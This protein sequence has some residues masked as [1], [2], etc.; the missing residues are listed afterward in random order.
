MGLFLWRIIKICENLSSISNCCSLWGRIM[1]MC[2]NLCGIKFI[3]INIQYRFEPIFSLEPIENRNFRLEITPLLTFGLWVQ[4]FTWAVFVCISVLFLN[5]LSYLNFLV[6]FLLSEKPGT[7]LVVLM[8]FVY[9]VIFDVLFIVNWGKL[10]RCRV[11]DRVGHLDGRLGLLWVL[12]A[13]YDLLYLQ[14]ILS[15]VFTHFC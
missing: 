3:H 2:Q 9:S 15:F 12:G 8:L 14:L 5:F 1:L 13:W 11:S 7:F 10:T 6:H 4:I